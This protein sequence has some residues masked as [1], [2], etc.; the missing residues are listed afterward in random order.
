MLRKQH[1]FP[2]SKNVSELVADTMIL[3]LP[4]CIYFPMFPTRKIFISQLSMRKT[5]SLHQTSFLNKI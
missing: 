1:F 3:S 5:A 4:A 2:G